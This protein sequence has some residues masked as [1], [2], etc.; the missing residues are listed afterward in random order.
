MK[1]GFKSELL[2][3][4][5]GGNILEDYARKQRFLDDFSRLKTPRILVHGGGK[6]ATQLAEKLHIKV[7]MVDGR[8]IT[9]AQMLDIVVMTYGGLVN[10]QL[11]A[12]LQSRGKSAL[13]LSGADLDLIRATKRVPKPVDFG[14]VGDIK[15][16]HSTPLLALLD[17]EITPVIAPLSHDGAGQLLNTNADTIAS[18]VA[19]ALV[20][21]YSVTL[22]SC[23]D[24]PGVMHEGKLLKELNFETFLRLKKVKAVT[25]GMIPKLQTGFEALKAGIKNV[26]LLRFDAL[27]DFSQTGTRLS[28]STS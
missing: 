10:K 24:Q 20:A 15:Q 14:F 25:D 4:K 1:K 16:V 18:C 7:N 13:G 23:F 17:Q 11:V 6:L 26:N 27:H 19:Q 3:V 5:V 12:D 28:L 8:R 2:V 22:L 21:S 9:D